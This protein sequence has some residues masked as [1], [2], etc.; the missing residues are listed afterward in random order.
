MSGEQTV[1]VDTHSDGGF[2]LVS[3]PEAKDLVF[4]EAVLADMTRTQPK[5]PLQCVT[6]KMPLPAYLRLKRA[7]QKW[8]LTLTDVINFCTE[9][10]VPVLE[11]PSGQVAALLEQ[12]RLEEEARRARNAARRRS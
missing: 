6:H 8:N 7:A 2:Q 12:H 1:K 10:I 9:R 3:A 11:A 5:R 4:L